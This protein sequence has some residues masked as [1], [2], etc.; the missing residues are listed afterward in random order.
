MTN[1]KLWKDRGWFPS[2]EMFDGE[3]P[4]GEWAAAVF[5]KNQRCIASSVT[6][7]GE[8]FPSPEL[9]L[10]WAWRTLTDLETEE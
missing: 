3:S 8:M 5:D 1:W 2:I 7:T 10:N 9:A 4:S 6:D